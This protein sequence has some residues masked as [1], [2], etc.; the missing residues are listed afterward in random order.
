MLAIDSVWRSQSGLTPK[1]YFFSI[2][3]INEKR[4][5]HVRME[6]LCCI[7]LLGEHHT[8]LT[9]GVNSQW[10]AQSLPSW[11]HHSRGPNEVFLVG[12]PRLTLSVFSNMLHSTKVKGWGNRRARFPSYFL[13][14]HEYTV[15]LSSQVCSMCYWLCTHQPQ[16]VVN[17]IKHLQC[18]SYRRLGSALP[19][20]AL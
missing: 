20:T 9:R 5:S 3:P 16:I 8:V 17:N 7:A 1:W 15:S 19:H 6:Q 18:G 10:H 11:C 12:P 13:Y 4:E 14:S 2:S